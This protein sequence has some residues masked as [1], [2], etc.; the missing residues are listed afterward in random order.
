MRFCVVEGSAGQAISKEKEVMPE[1]GR[2]NPGGQ[3][4]RKERQA[5]IGGHGDRI[6]RI[7][8]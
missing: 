3:N 4:H 1:K 8:L 5:S 2:M 6:R 7:G